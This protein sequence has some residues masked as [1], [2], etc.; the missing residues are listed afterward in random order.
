[1]LKK[2]PGNK[3]RKLGASHEISR[4][5]HRIMQL[6]KFYD[7]AIKTSR[8]EKNYYYNCPKTL[9]W[10]ERHDLRTSFKTIDTLVLCYNTHTKQ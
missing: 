6:C 10:R 2:C 7:K 3:L 9:N 4:L 8:P 5:R 1:M